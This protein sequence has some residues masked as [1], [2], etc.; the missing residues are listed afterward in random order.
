MQIVFEPASKTHLDKYKARR[1][2]YYIY[3]AAAELWA[4]GMPFQKA[5]SIVSNAFRAATHEV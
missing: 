3:Q 2:Q 5:V 1:S 4:E